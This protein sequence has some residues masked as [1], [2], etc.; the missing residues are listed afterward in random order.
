MQ[1]INWPNFSSKRVLWISVCSAGV[2]RHKSW[3][4]PSSKCCC[5]KRKEKRGKHQLRKFRPSIL[6]LIKQIN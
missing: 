2:D 5:G 6:K 4:A 3:L 1:K